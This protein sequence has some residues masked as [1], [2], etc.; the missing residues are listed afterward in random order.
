VV[1]APHAFDL[2]ADLRDW[3]AHAPKFHGGIK[4]EVD[5]GPQSFL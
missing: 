3:I 1:K 4:L 5:I 2:S